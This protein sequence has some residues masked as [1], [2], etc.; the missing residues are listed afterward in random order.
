MKVGAV[1]EQY[2][3]LPTLVQP[4]L[5][6][7]DLLTPMA[8]RLVVEGDRIDHHLSA[9]GALI[10][11]AHVQ[12]FQGGHGANL[13]A[14]VATAREQTA[15]CTP[16]LE[17]IKNKPFYFSRLFQVQITDAYLNLYNDP[18]CFV[19]GG[20]DLGSLQKDAYAT[21]QATLLDPLL[22]CEPRLRFYDRD[23]KDVLTPLRHLLIMQTLHRLQATES[24]AMFAVF[25]ANTRERSTPTDSVQ[26]EVFDAKVVFPDQTFI[27]FKSAPHTEKHNHP[28][29]AILS[30]NN[31]S[32]PQDMFKLAQRMSREVAGQQLRDIDLKSL[33][34]LTCKVIGAMVKPPTVGESAYSPDDNRTMIAASVKL[35]LN[36]KLTDLRAKLSQ[37]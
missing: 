2:R 19:G 17:D 31:F 14:T 9:A 29:T 37:L 27:A 25:P 34:R 7:A 6:D 33:D 13:E 32:H 36:D 12:Q 20:W 35:W 5:L 23:R 1:N 28:S 21:T 11:L 15:K 8:A 22:A 30:G 16:L 18:R 3:G 26:P 10:D 4:H 24:M